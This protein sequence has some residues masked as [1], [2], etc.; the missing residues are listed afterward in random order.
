[1]VSLKGKESKSTSQNLEYRIQLGSYDKPLVSTGKLA[2][3]LN[4][5]EKIQEELFN[6][7][8]IYT[9]GSFKSQQEA[10]LR[11]KEIQ[12]YTNTTSSFIVS[13]R[14]GARTPKLEKS[15]LAEK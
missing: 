6:G 4:I 13:F 10:T 2:A 8:Y 11:N 1:V 12:K 14:N 3:K 9:I 15:E 7:H 5:T